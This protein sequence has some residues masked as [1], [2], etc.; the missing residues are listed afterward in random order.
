MYGGVNGFDKVE[1]QRA[2]FWTGVRYPSPPPM[3]GLVMLTLCSEKPNGVQRG[4]S[5]ALCLYRYNSVG[6]VTDF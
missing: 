1:S 2:Q 6:R 3:K 4:S 5:D